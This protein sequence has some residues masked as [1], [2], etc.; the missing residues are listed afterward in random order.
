M[1]RVIVVSDLIGHL[2]LLLPQSGTVG[3][4]QMAVVLRLH[5]L[6]FLVDVGLLLLQR[7]GLASG[8]PAVVYTLRNAPL[9]VLF[10]LVD[11]LRSFGWACR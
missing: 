1:D 9:L 4:C 8:Q 11:A 5:G 3:S 7:A 2:I 6:L 10:V